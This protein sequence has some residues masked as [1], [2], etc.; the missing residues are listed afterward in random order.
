MLK[1]SPG[2]VLRVDLKPRKQSAKHE[3][4]KVGSLEEPPPGASLTVYLKGE[5]P[6]K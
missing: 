5:V 1:R 6:E 4:F 3:V 2:S